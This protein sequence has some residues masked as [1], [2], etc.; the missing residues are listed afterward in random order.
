MKH[1][2]LA[3][4]ISLYED[5]FD[6]S[7]VDRFLSDLEEQTKSDWSDLTWNEGSTEASTVSA[8]RSSLTC[9]M[10]PLMKPYERTEL[11]ELFTE[12]IRNP[13]EAVTTDYLSE[14]FL[15]TSAFEPY[16]LLKYM[17]HAEYKAHWDHSSSNSRVAS[18]VAFLTAPEEG[19]QL[20]FPRFNITIEAK[21]G[22]VVLFPSNFPYI[23]IA[24]PVTAGIK[25]SLVT[26]HQG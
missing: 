23:H 19:G 9:S 2:E 15:T 25:H 7:D 10:I 5:V 17:T 11:S 8:Y 16:Q 13:I 14:F 12:K 26:W 18:M 24:H 3:T 22:S 4:C 21:C 6:S 20:E 1:T